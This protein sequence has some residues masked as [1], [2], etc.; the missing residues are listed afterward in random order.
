MIKVKAVLGKIFNDFSD[1]NVFKKA[2]FSDSSHF[3][4]PVCKRRGDFKRIHPYCR[5]MITI[6]DDS[7][8]DVLV[9][10]PRI[11]CP[12]CNHTHALLPDNLIPF[13]S[14][15]IHFVLKVLSEYLKRSVPVAVLCEN[16]GISIS[17]LYSWKK[18]L[19]YHHSI[20]LGI[21]HA[22]ESLCEEILSDITDY[23]SLPEAFFSTFGFSFLQYH[24]T[25]SCRSPA[26]E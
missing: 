1:E 20:L 26:P 22:M 4:C 13:G 25:F 2:D 23:D 16:Y 24:A 10:V 6:A 7:R 3:K 18:L 15:T 14:Y 8:K 17:T 12:S 19:T 21:M 5:Y 11:Q 9:E